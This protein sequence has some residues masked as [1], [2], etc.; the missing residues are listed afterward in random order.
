MPSCAVTTT[1]TVFTPTL[2]E[3]GVAGLAPF[4]VT[5][6]FESATVGV[7]VMLVVALGTA[8]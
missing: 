6:A 7:I 3:T 4:T 1:G 5:V 2:S 8:T